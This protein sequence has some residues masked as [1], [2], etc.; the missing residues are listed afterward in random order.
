M[1]L[2]AEETLNK[3]P[4]VGTSGR[5]EKFQ[6]GKLAEHRG[7]KIDVVIKESVAGYM[8]RSTFNSVTEIITFLESVK[9]KLPSREEVESSSSKIPRL[10]IAGDTR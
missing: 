1:P 7:K 6:L 9:V 3:I 5:A 2:A 10:P 8:E 4:L